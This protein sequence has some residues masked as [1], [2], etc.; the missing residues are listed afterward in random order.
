MFGGTG[1]M[2]KPVHSI[3]FG[4]NTV[5]HCQQS[6]NNVKKIMLSVLYIQRDISMYLWVKVFTLNFFAM[7]R[8]VLELVNI[9]VIQK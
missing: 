9:A 3:S 7:K 4:S 5:L 8:R 2:G 1:F 6:F